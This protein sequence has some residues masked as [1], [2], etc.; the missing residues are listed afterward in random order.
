MSI[1]TENQLKTLKKG[2]NIQG[3]ILCR[4]YSLSNTKSGSEYVQG[5]LQSGIE[6][7]FKA[8]N[9]SE[10]FVQFKN[11]D[12]VGQVCY[13]QGRVDDYGG[14]FSIIAETVQA[15]EGEDVSQFLPERYDTENYWNSL[16]ALVQ[17]KVTPE[18]FAIANANLF[19]KPEVA[20]L[21]K[22][23]FAASSHHD[24]CKGGLLAH[25]YKVVYY[26]TTILSMYPTLAT[27]PKAK[28]ILILGALFHDIGKVKEMNVG[29]YQPCSKV[30]HRYLGIE[31]IDKASFVA[32]YG[33]DGWLELVSIF[34][35]HHGDFEDKCRTASAFIVHKADCFDAD[36]TYLAQ[37]E[38]K[39]AVRNGVQTIKVDSGWLSI[40]P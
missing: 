25:T 11:F 9:N 20:T 12:Y 38:E 7:P 17:Q 1:I 18:G 27:T 28:D 21:F 24:N 14:T 5:T 6:I 4:T 2:D 32:T 31:M 35:Q 3:T 16:I 19:N 22:R 13:I 33:E 37:A 36:M 30:S 15:V 26:V 34:L 8:W 40:M 23:E 10:A 29:V 39:P